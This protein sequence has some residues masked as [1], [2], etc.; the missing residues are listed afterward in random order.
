MSTLAQQQYK[1]IEHRVSNAISAWSV[2][3]SL[4]ATLAMSAFAAFL[5]AC[6]V[7]SL[8]ICCLGD[9]TSIFPA[10]LFM[11]LASI[12][13]EE[14]QNSLRS[15][16]KLIA[17]IS[18]LALPVA[19]LVSFFWMLLHFGIVSEHLVQMLKFARFFLP[20]MIFDPSMLSDL[21]CSADGK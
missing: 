18:C 2:I 19:F 5:F 4:A 6:S 7:M 15:L 21:G 17:Q 16:V 10:L 12:V 9:G 14:M 3:L 20:P 8:I 11:W 13:L 1:P